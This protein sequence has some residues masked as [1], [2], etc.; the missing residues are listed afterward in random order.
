MTIEYV[1]YDLKSST[2]AQFI[3]GYAQ[4]VAALKAAPE[5]LGYD[6][7]QCEEDPASFILRIRWQSTRAHLEGFR[8]GPHFQ[9]FFRAVS[10]F[11][12]EIAEMR[13]YSP[14]DLDWVR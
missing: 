3:A 5:C 12:T 6:L 4:A 14:T 7:S 9:T 2:P 10:P 8:K 11:Y 13:H 1:R